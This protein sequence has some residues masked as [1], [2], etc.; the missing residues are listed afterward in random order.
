MGMLDEYLKTLQA[1]GCEG[2]VAHID[3]FNAETEGWTIQELQS[4]GVD[5]ILGVYQRDPVAGLSVA[6]NLYDRL[7]RDLI[8]RVVKRV[9]HQI[10]AVS[11]YP[12]GFTHE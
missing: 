2:I 6:K 11:A 10:N 3:A 4:A 7:A 1:E 12:E 5:F 9:N 8:G